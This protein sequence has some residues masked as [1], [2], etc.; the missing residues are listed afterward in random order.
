MT[1]TIVPINDAPV[2]TGEVV[3]GN[4]DTVLSFNPVDLLTNDADVDN[5]HA[6]LTVTA[7]G[8]AHH[9]TVAWAEDGS[10]KVLFTPDA[11]Y[12][13]TADF[14]YTIAD[15]VGGTA[16]ATVTISLADV[17]DAPIAH[18]DAASGQEDVPLVFDAA[19]LTGND[20]DIEGDALSI[21]AVGQASGGVAAII[22]GQVVFTPTADYNGPA[23]FAYTVS[24]GRG[25]L[26]SA[27]M[28]LDLAAVNDAPVVPAT[29]V[30]GVEETALVIAPA[31]LL[32][33][34]S[35][36]DNVHAALDITAIG[37]ASHGTVERLGNGAIQFTPD[38]NFDG[39]ASFAYTVADGVGG[40][41]TGTATVQV[42][43]INDAPVATGETIYS[44]EDVVLNLKSALLANDT[45][46]DNPQSDLR[47]VGVT[48][49]SHCS[50][51][52]NGDG[53]AYFV[54]E[55]NYYGNASFAYTVGDGAG[56]TATATANINLA[57][58]ND[59]PIAS[60]ESAT[61]YED[62]IANF[63]KSALLANDTDV[64]TPWG[65]DIAN[66]WGASGGSVSMSGGNIA[67]APTANYNGYAGFGY[68]VTDGS[69]GA[70]NAWVNLNYLPVNDAPVANGES[71]TSRAGIASNISTAA[72][73]ANDTDVE[74]PNSLSVSQVYN[75]QYGS[76][77][78]SGSSVVFTPQAGYSGTASF[79]YLVSDP[80]GAA[81][82]ATVQVTCAANQSPIATDDSFPGYEDTLFRIA[83]S[84][85][86]SNDY[87]PDDPGQ[88]SV[89]SV[90]SASHGSVGIVGD[91]VHFMPDANYSGAASFQYTVSDPLGAS[92]RATAYLNVQAVNDAPVITG[93]SYVG[94]DATA[95]LPTGQTGVDAE[96]GTYAIQAPALVDDPFRSQG[97]VSASDPE[98]QA[99]SCSILTAPQHGHAWANTHV[100]NSVAAGI[101][102]GNV[103]YTY[104]Y[105]L[106]KGMNYS[107]YEWRGGGTSITWSSLPTTWQYFSNYGDTYS[108]AD[109]FTIR[110]TD[111]EGAFADTVINVNHCGT[112]INTGG[113]GG[114]PV[115]LDLNDNS[116]IDLVSPED[117]SMF[118]DIN[119][120]GWKDQIGWAAPGDGVLC[121]DANADGQ[122][123]VIDEVS[124]TQYKEGARTDLE[125]L[126]GLDSSGD[127]VISSAD[128]AWSQMGVVAGG[129]SN[130]DGA[131][132]NW[133][134]LDEA[135]VAAVGLERQGEPEMNQGNVVFGTSTV[136]FSDGH[137]SVAGDVMLAGAGVPLPD[138]V[139]ALFDGQAATSST[140]AANLAA[141]EAV[142]SDAAS[143]AG[144]VALPA[145][146]EVAPVTDVLVDDATSSNAGAT[147]V[148]TSNAEPQAA[149][150]AAAMMVEMPGTTTSDTSDTSTTPVATAAIADTSAAETMTDAA[151][152]EVVRPA[153]D[154]SVDPTANTPA[155]V[156][157]D[158]QAAEALAASELA[159]IRQQ[160]LLFNQVIATAD[161][162]DTAPLAYVP[163]EP[164]ASEGLGASVAEIVPATDLTAIAA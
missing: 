143:V 152:D 43:N 59:A 100:P 112:S 39:A 23:S 104:D 19:Q 27:T 58:V 67:F 94:T 136:T 60:G 99:W 57:A 158:L 151:V 52:V 119:Q 137:T 63:S 162:S 40:Q 125:G 34:A 95:L 93:V 138:E 62:N 16:D 69:G 83:K 164:V 51:S 26:C 28:N 126:A 89:T 147:E 29:I 96:G 86:T 71:V 22:G 42:A 107:L 87:D 79:Q 24:D 54:P 139:A 76:V 98:G 21:V 123:N 154:A 56:G 156:A 91:D 153:L 142:T 55:S 161:V 6:E 49:A 75:A 163:P 88:I 106:N 120:D 77:S 50:V 140:I 38:Q 90:D 66:V 78:L 134:S 72:L 84:Q 111:S 64:E 97:W 82:A 105:S 128:E 160:A 61:L 41:T 3:N 73:L 81:A 25:G 15:G 92:T 80:Q 8:A 127:G 146:A 149:E 116:A 7:L 145:P 131:P 124:F 118:A 5:A 114:C 10:G 108:G 35:D 102:D 2:A 117:S 103:M 14:A 47:V 159:R 157:E 132:V 18:D 13:G 85:L 11:N 4:E 17:N 36:V 70:S 45:D 1:L 68:T 141:T 101:T 9:G 121:Y 135:G 113:G 20:T 48:G 31:V 110:V 44:S 155:A 115:V 65:L 148:A 122:I 37:G 74:T 32:A 130:A 46:V 12:F 53:S 144:A 30:A 109:P 133:I 150:P 129:A 33:N